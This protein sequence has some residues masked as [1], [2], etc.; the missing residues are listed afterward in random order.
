MELKVGDIVELKSGGP[1]MTIE[2]IDSWGPIA[3]TLG[4]EM[5]N[6]EKD[7]AKCVWFEG[8]KKFDSIFKL[9]ALN[10]L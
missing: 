7:E 3:F 9:K 1:R 8:N 2:E 5:P 6:Y 4:E 10:K